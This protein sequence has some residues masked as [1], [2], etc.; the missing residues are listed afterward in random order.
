[1]E[2]VRIIWW[3]GDNEFYFQ[4]YWI[5][6]VEKYDRYVIPRDS[7]EELAID[8]SSKC[9]IFWLGWLMSLSSGILTNS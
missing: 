5:S 3:P 1:M 4:G 2:L 6:N 7:H 8:S 9:S